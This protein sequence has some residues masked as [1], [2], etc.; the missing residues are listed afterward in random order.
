MSV[1]SDFPPLHKKLPREPLTYE[2]FL[3]W[4]DDETSAEWVDGKVVLMSPSRSHRG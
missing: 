2:Q 3:E 1:R 4:C